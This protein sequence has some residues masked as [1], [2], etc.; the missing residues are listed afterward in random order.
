MLACRSAAKGQASAATLTEM[1]GAGS[2]WVVELDLARL[3]SIRAANNDV[4]ALTDGL[5]GIVT[6]AGIMQTPE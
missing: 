4:R 1:P 3:G 2:V 5:D 6:N